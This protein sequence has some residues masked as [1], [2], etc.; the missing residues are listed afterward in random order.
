MHYEEAALSDKNHGEVSGEVSGGLP[1]R[2]TSLSP[3]EKKELISDLI[4]KSYIL[5]DISDIFKEEE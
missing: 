4:K 5:L 3:N 1:T 2:I